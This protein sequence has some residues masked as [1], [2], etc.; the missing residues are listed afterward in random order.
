MQ[1]SA[2]H[3]FGAGKALISTFGPAAGAASPLYSDSVSL[4]SNVGNARVSNLLAFAASQFS[5]GT[6]MEHAY[7]GIG[8]ALPRP[9][10]SIGFLAPFPLPALS[11][12]AVRKTDQT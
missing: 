5:L 3:R 6:R 2:H 4:F 10:K 1:H 11:H 7:L 9:Y 12:Y 8:K